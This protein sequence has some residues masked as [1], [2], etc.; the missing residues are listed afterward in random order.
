MLRVL[1]MVAL[2]GFGTVLL[3]P[4]TALANCEC[5]QKGHILRCHPS[6]AS[7]RAEGGDTCDESRG[8]RGEGR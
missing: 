2:I 1:A 5:Y 6:L 7:C 8:C 4:A 3:I